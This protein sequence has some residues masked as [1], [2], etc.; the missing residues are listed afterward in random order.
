MKNSWDSD[1]GHLALEATTAP[2]VPQ[3]LPV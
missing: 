3:H 1:C 2:S